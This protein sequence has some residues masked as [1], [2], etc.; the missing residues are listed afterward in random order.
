VII[1]DVDV[2]D[3]GEGGHAVRGG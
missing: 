3:S 2:G 1:G